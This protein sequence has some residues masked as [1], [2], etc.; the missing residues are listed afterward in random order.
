MT[1]QKASSKLV[2]L[3]LLILALIVGGYSLFIWFIINIMQGD[4]A[5]GLLFVALVAGIASFFNP[6]SFPLL[7]AYLTQYFGSDNRKKLS[8]RKKIL[9]YGLIAALG[10]ITFNILL[11]S[12]IG[13]LGIGFGKSLALAGDD[14]NLILRWVRGIVGVILFLLGLNH[15]TGRGIHFRI[16]ERYVSKRFPNNLKNPKVQIFSYGFAYTLLGIGCGGPILAGLSIFALS[17][18]GFLD[19][20]L[21]FLVYSFVMALL[22]LVVSSL[23]AFSK[24]TLI[25]DLSGNVVLVKKVSG[26]LLLIVGLFLIL[27]SIYITTFTEVLFP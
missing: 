18:G 25:K 27:S 10:V 2:L 13:V 4:A 22:M 9:L 6:C 7:P 17:Q 8:N 16:I 15:I 12:L 1:E 3:I 21:A 20:F 23:I 5:Y 19:A 11:G 24:Q 14:P 26:F